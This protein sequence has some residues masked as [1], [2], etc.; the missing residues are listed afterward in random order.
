MYIVR[1]HI[2]E[3]IRVS[4]HILFAVRDDDDDDE[5]DENDNN[6]SE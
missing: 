6:N 1:V 2:S 3:T 5:H 4:H